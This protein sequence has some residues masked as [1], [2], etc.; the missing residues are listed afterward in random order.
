MLNNGLDDEEIAD[1]MNYILNSWGNKSDEII[2]KE[3]V[4]KISE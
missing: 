2:T 4:A 1:V 3:R